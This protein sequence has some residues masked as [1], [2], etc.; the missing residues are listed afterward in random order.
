MPLLTILIPTIGRISD[1]KIAIEAFID[2][3]QQ[4]EVD[5]DQVEIVVADNQ[6]QDGTAEYGIEL[7]HRYSFIRY[8]RHDTF[9]PTAEDSILNAVGWCRGEYLWTFG[10]DDYATSGAVTT[11]LA[12]IKR[13]DPELVLINMH[14]IEGEK[15]LKGIDS[16]CDHVYDQGLEMFNALGVTG[17]LSACISSVCLKRAHYDTVLFQKIAKISPVYSIPFFLL[18]K[19]YKKKT[20]VL[21]EPI[22]TYKLNRPVQEFKNISGLYVRNGQSAYF[23]WHLGLIRLSTFVARYTGISFEEMMMFSEA[24][25][26]GVGTNEPLRR[27]H[28]LL[29]EFI[30]M[31]VDQELNQSFED[32]YLNTIFIDFLVEIKSFYKGLTK[33]VIPYSSGGRRISGYLNRYHWLASGRGSVYLDK[34]VG[35]YL[36]Q[37]LYH[38]FVWTKRRSVQRLVTMLK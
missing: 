9:W 2:S 25:T 29:Y 1:L 36:N 24:T 18:C 23:A 33:L 13:H 27:H 14:C 12:A 3:I 30:S 15:S 31:Y 26:S 32:I 35:Y 37:W 5:L 21:A 22:F 38:V 10:D 17:G 11:L 7:S 34:R 19:V 4:G 6:S 20:L 8:H 16:D 28:M